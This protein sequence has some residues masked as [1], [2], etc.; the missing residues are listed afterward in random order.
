MGIADMLQLGIIKAGPIKIMYRGKLVKKGKVHEDSSFS[1][2]NNTF[3][4]PSGFALHFIRKLANPDITTISG[5]M[6]IFQGDYSLDQLRKMY[7]KANAQ[8]INELNS[9]A[10]TDQVLENDVNSLLD[11]RIN[12]LRSADGNSNHVLLQVSSINSNGGS[13][14]RFPRSRTAIASDLSLRNMMKHGFLKPQPVT[15]LYH[16]AHRTGGKIT[17]KGTFEVDG[18]SWETPSGFAL[19]IAKKVNP[20]LRTINGFSAVRINNVKLSVYRDKFKVYIAEEKKRR[21]KNRNQAVSGAKSEMKS[22]G[23]ASIVTANLIEDTTTTTITT[24]N[25]TTTTTATMSVTDNVAQSL[26]EISNDI[27]ATVEPMNISDDEK[28]DNQNELNISSSSAGTTVSTSGSY[29]NDSGSGAHGQKSKMANIYEDTHDNQDARGR[30]NS[31]ISFSSMEEEYSNVITPANNFVLNDEDNSV[32]SLSGGLEYWLLLGGKLRGMKKDRYIQKLCRVDENTVAWLPAVIV[33]N[34]SD[35]EYKIKFVQD[36]DGVRSSKLSSYL[37]VS[38]DVWRKDEN[39]DDDN[40]D[41]SGR[42][43]RRRKKIPSRY[44]DIPLNQ[45]QFTKS[46]KRS[47]SSSSINSTTSNTTKNKKKKRKSS[48]SWT[49]NG[50]DNENRD[51]D[52]EQDENEVDLIAQAMELQNP[53]EGTEDTFLSSGS[54]IA[55]L[56]AAG[57]VCKAVDDVMRPKETRTLRNAFCLVRPPGHHVGRFGRTVGCCSHGFCLMNNVGIGAMKA[58]VDHDCK[59]IAIIDF[60]VHF[61]NG[62]YEIFRNDKDTLF[63]SVHMTGD[64]EGNIFFGANLPGVNEIDT[65]NNNICIS[66]EGGKGNKGRTRFSTAFLRTVLPA[67]KKFNPELIMISAGF[68]GHKD[69]PLGGHLGL[70]AKDFRELTYHVV[71]LAEGENMACQGRVVSVLEGGYDCKP[72]GSLPKCVVAHVKA[73]AE[74]NPIFDERWKKDLVVDTSFMR[75]DG[76]SSSGSAISGAMNGDTSRKRGRS[77]RSGRTFVCSPTVSLSS[78]TRSPQNNVHFSKGGKRIRLV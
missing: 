59:K 24:T 46:R 77:R 69:D 32:T 7:L 75:V 58:R 37:D 68:D 4:T 39:D 57:V 34:V 30:T 11:A 45:K 29:S 31:T 25:T 28:H 16:Q 12:S 61:G 67:L 54:H 35:T 36:I 2:G 40:G 21:D 5:Y 10:K 13:V 8:K 63:I 56:H 20:N 1:C 9:K 27:S 22:E 18:E 65:V 55:C 52:D 19:Y 78:P 17:A 62:T 6:A 42:S 33:R 64:G 49:D 53:L 60:D 66:I 76:S 70:I 3:E 72:Q 47:V 14:S 38:V 44:R 73:M 43:S 23:A 41:Q 48:T 50:Y 26:L 51:A 74:K 71:K 15:V